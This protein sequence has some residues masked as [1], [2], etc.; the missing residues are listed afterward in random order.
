MITKKIFS[1]LL[2]FA[3]L[4]QGYAQVEK[5]VTPPFNIK[6]VAFI[7]N[8]N[9]MIP[10]FRLGDSFQLEFDDLYGNEA[11]YYYTITQYNYDWTPTQLGKAEY[12]QG[13]DNQRIMNYQNSFNTLQIY[14]H[15][16]QTFPNKFNRILLT[17]NYMLKI[18]N[19]DQELVFSRKFIIYDEQLS[20][21]LQIKRSRD[22]STIDGMQNLDFVVKMGDNILQ[23]PIQNVKVALFQN[24]RLD[25]AIYNVKPQYT[26]GSDLIYRYNKET[27]FW[28]G[29]EYLYFEN[30]DI[31]TVSNNVGHV[32]AGEIY[33]THL[34]MNTARRN[35]PYTYFPDI[36]GRFLPNKINAENNN[37]EADYSWVYFTLNTNTFMDKKDVYIVGMFNNYSLSPEYKMDYN[38]EKG[39]FEKAILI[40]QGF[41]NYQYAIAD[42]NGKID[43]E[44][45][46]DGNFYQTENN[47][48]VLVYYRGNNDRYDRVIGRG[49]ATSES[50]TN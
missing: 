5:E 20:V 38:A 17:G 33:N 24:G 34:Y 16:S 35:N 3:S 36:N 31:R 40:K 23:N 49:I 28:A 14:S 21:P 12:L 18:F 27:Q 43:Q 48:F 2:V 50:I 32:S 13:M 44:N 45:A 30:K 1:L 8:G 39:L 37:L 29:N 11:D 46:V 6:T 47:Y 7:Q 26:I 42:K 19:S 9:V 25:N 22:L 15:Y 41:T 4:V 10:M